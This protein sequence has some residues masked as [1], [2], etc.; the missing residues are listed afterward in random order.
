VSRDRPAGD[1][2]RLTVN[3]DEQVVPAE[4]TV[5]SLVAGLGLE[6]RGVA[7]AVDG[8]VVPRRTWPERT[9]RAGEQVEI[10]T[11]AQGG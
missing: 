10:L 11:I 4:A 7:V 5:A 2:V 6:P 9:L 3:G 1:A 8:E